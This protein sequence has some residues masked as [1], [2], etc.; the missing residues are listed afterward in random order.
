MSSLI[1]IA[2][3]GVMAYRTA[4]SVTTENV[5]NANTEGYLRREAVLAVRPGASMTPDSAA[6]LGGGVSISE[7]R[8]AFDGLTAQRLWASESTR[9]AAQMQATA[10][11]ALEQQLSQGAE[12]LGA[13]MTEFFDGMNDLAS[14]PGDLGLRRIVMQK[15]GS[16]AASFA[17]TGQGL[18][19]LRQEALATLRL[20]TDKVSA[21]LGDLVATNRKMVAVQT[22]AGAENGLL[23]H[24]D[25]LL[26]S[27]SAEIGI[28]VSLDARGQ[29]MVRLGS[30]GGP[31]LVD[32]SGAARL[33]LAGEE[34]P[35]FT[36]SG[37]GRSGTAAVTVASGGIGGQVAALAGLEAAEIELDQLAARLVS[38]L[39]AVQH[40]G[41]DLDGQP[42][43]DLLTAEG[44]DIWRGPT[45]S[46]LSRVTVELGGRAL[47]ERMTLDYDGTA[48]EWRLRDTAG[49]I[50]ARGASTLAYQGATITVEGSARM[51]DSYTL[52]PRSG[53]ARD[54]A[55]ALTDPRQIAAAAATISAPAP[56]NLGSASAAILASPRPDSG[57][58][59]LAQLLGGQGAANATGLIQSGVVGVIPAGT[60]SVD[61]VSYARQ[62]SADLMV[63]EAALMQGGSLRLTL[64]GVAERFDFGP[65]M[66]AAQ[67]AD[68]LNGGAIL[69][70]SGQ[71]F[72]E[73]GLRAAGTAGQMSLALAQGDFATVELALPSGTFPA[74]TVPA[75][76]RAS[77]LMVF[78]RDGRQVAGAP[79]DAGGAARL[80]TEANGFAAGAAYLAEALNGA[81]GS[82]YRGMSVERMVLPGVQALTYD[83]PAGAAAMLTLRA[84]DQ[85]ATV[86]RPEGASAARLAAR[87]DGALAGL[88]ARAETALTLSGLA[89]G[90]VS[91][92]LTG[93]NDA[94]FAISARIEAGDLSA[95]ARAINAAGAATGI[96]AEVSADGG[97]LRLRQAGGEDIRI[98]GFAHDA[99]GQMV[100]TPVD[101]TGRARA[102]AVLL[103][104]GG[105]AAAR[106][107]GQ[108]HL[109]GPIAFSL[110][111]PLGAQASASDAG[112]GGALRRVTEAAGDVV[113]LRMGAEAAADGGGAAADGL[114]V[115]AAGWSQRLSVNGVQVQHRGA[116]SAVEAAEG[117]LAALRAEAPGA[118]LTGAPVASPPPEGA[119]MALRLDGQDYILRM[120]AGQPVID[121]PE[122]N[123][124]SASFDAGGRLQLA[125]NG[126]VPDGMGLQPDITSPWAS[127]FGLGAGAVHRL[128]GQPVDP[129]ALPVAGQILSLRLGDTA[130]E[131]GLS[132]VGG[133]LQLT[134]PADFPA[135]AQLDGQ[136]RIVIDIPA[137]AGQMLILPGG[138]AA[139]LA[140]AGVTARRAGEELV[141]TSVI[142]TPPDLAIE[143]EATAAERLRLTGLP[144]ED[145]IVVMAPGGALRLG[146]ALTAATGPQ[147]ARA[148]DLRITDAATGA[149]ELLD[150]DSGHSIAS[151][152][153]D[154][155]GQATIGDY[156]VTLTGRPAEG[157]RFTLTPNRNPAGDGRA[158]LA[159]AALASGDRAPGGGFAQ[160]LAELTSDVGA[161]THA[162]NLKAQ[163]EAAGHEALSRKMAEMGAVDLDTEAARL[164]ELQQA[165]QASA[166][167][168]TIAR[169]LFD[170][171]LNMM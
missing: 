71:R 112:A 163:A 72:A 4:L 113:R 131:L 148:T 43:Q 87:L 107:A 103:S 160:M 23:D 140:T 30:A 120:Q 19:V 151:G 100:V 68:A 70:A 127:A 155:R 108:V 170:T 162:A 129:A 118:A 156:Q 57:L 169:Q 47:A 29:A 94:P 10:G 149:I 21:L 91:F 123:R 133:G 18:R 115:A 143:A 128:T 86:E 161:R 130:Y 134:V 24:R 64:G 49:G 109:S 7:V 144:P 34:P 61:L 44:V 31:V 99:G 105:Q 85:A 33:E 73:W 51:G 28:S 8:R 110:I 84:G 46:G 63:P 76:A 53:R 17:E 22:P 157:D 139:G 62:A 45:N 20:A 11:Q 150:R 78:T 74:V 145:L 52:M 168:L 146:G 153:L 12:G 58:T 111:S 3:S 116:T 121:G 5:A 159:M 136:N 6:T 132:A 141:L 81:E 13:A 137:A 126:G 69:G 158:A 90:Q 89:D 50:V 142:G 82:G 60:A 98:E 35:Q 88:V 95:L 38:S 152:W 96:A 106:V 65:G 138:G 41:V 26:T 66:T 104:A 36:L 55:F 80:L 40:G 75:E 83:V 39:N 165:Y 124:L 14:Q 15:A 101:E 114:G 166:Q 59:P 48:R 42:G 16:L 164:I 77:G 102:G 79:L 167:T 119:A 135:Q 37:P 67:L 27:L 122:G 25:A 2:R 32:E 154:A 97:R 56:G 147:P 92:A 9:G 117:L 171:I 93:A 1:D 54:M 125:V